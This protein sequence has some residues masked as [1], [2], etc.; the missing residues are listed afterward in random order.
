M[1]RMSDLTKKEQ[2]EQS[3]KQ[4][5]QEKPDGLFDVKHTFI[6]TSSYF[7]KPV[8]I[9]VTVGIINL[10]WIFLHYFA[11]HLYVRYCVPNTIQGFLVSPFMVS[12]PHC[13]GL[14]WMIYNGGNNI[15][16][17]WTLVGTWI[18]SKLLV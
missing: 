5:E 2:K 13:Q 3:E 6:I 14:R 4:S 7:E 12:T 8:K 15:T 9:I 11:S 10:L 17:M 16:N 1:S 18:Y